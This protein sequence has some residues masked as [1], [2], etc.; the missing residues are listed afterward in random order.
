VNVGVYTGLSTIDLKDGTRSYAASGYYKPNAARKNL[1]VL[2]DAHVSK[3]ALSPTD[4]DLYRAEGI[5]F[6]H[7][8]E[9]YQVRGVRREVVLSAGSLQTPQILELSGIGNPETLK[10]HDIKPLVD[11][12]GVGENLRKPYN[13]LLI[14]AVADLL[15]VLYK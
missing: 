2:T 9:T 8:N 5:D 12:P 3:V 6:I 4:G 1:L 7:N 11:L 15:L 13:T 10:K 14:E